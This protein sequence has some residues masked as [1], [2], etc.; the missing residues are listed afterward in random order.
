[1]KV[2]VCGS[3]GDMPTLLNAI[4]LLRRSG[5]DIIMPTEE[6]LRDSQP[7]IDAHHLGKE[8]TTQTRELRA[9]LEA[10]YL[11]KIRMADLVYFVNEKFSDEHLGTGAAVELGFTLALQLPVMFH[12]EP[13]K[14]ASLIA[15]VDQFRKKNLLVYNHLVGR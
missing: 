3:F 8:E 4:S 2:V 10:Q 6:H 7:C 11:A 5:H 13:K 1:M 15:F 12:R 9:W 14:D